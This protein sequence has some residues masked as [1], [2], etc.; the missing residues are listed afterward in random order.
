MRTFPQPD[1]AH[2]FSLFA[3]LTSIGSESMYE[4][5]VSRFIKDYCGEL[6]FPC[7][8][9]SA[10][11]KTGGQCGNLF[12]TVPG[13]NCDLDPFII[14]S[15]MD[16]VMPGSN[17]VPQEEEDRF[18]SSGD[19]ILGAD[20]KAGIAA[21]LAA[22]ETLIGSG[23]DYRSIQ[24]V[25]TVQE[26]IGL[27]GSKNMDY[28]MIEGSWGIVLDGEGDV[29]GIVVKAPSQDRVKFE[30]HGRAAHA[31][32]EPE[33]GI[34]AISCASRA[35][36]ELQLGRIDESTTSNIGIIDGGKAINI[37][38]DYVVV[39]GEARSF[40]ESTL[41]KVTGGMEEAFKRS[42][43]ES[44]CEIDSEIERSFYGFD[45]DV[46]S[47]PIR[48]VLKAI[49]ESGYTPSY[50]TSGGGSDTNV[51]NRMGLQMVTGSIGLG[52]PHSLEEFIMKDQL[53]AIARV[54]VTLAVTSTEE[55]VRRDE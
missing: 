11:E 7:V 20:D 23:A 1:P 53:V 49:E 21:T 29:G 27:V 30:V 3:K 50:L 39:E 6:G 31:G 55:V 19:T 17:V 33:K 2:I 28:G 34:N 24:L 41:K 54:L 25:F 18:T 43:A 22:V 52:N 12:V 35:I 47:V 10:G 32:V 51:F 13:K 8:E 37:V 26:E 5:D 46:E 14:C 36:A 45:L 42:A 16:T 44:G 9:D 38:P 40:D 48:Q 4:E 15:H